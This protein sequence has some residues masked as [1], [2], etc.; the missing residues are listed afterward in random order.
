MHWGESRQDDDNGTTPS[1]P[2]KYNEGITHRSKVRPAGG[3]K[4]KRGNS[5][6]SPKKNN[7]CSL[8]ARLDLAKFV[9]DDDALMADVEGAQGCM[10]RSKRWE[11]VAGRLGEIG[12]SRTAEDCR[13]LKKWVELV[14]K[15][16]EIRD[17]CEGLRK[18]AYWDTTTKQ[19]RKLGKSVTCDDTLAS[20][21]LRGGGSPSGG[22]AGSEG[23]G[24]DAADT[25]TKTRHTSSGKARGGDSPASMYM[26]SVME[27]STRALCEVLDKAVGTLARASTDGSRMVATE[28]RAVVGAMRQGNA[29]LETLVGVMAARGAGSG[30]GAD[31]SRDTDP[32]TTSGS[33][34]A[35]AASNSDPPAKVG[36]FIPDD[37][38]MLTIDI[39]GDIVLKLVENLA[40][41]HERRLDMVTW[42]AAVVNVSEV[43]MVWLIGLRL[44]RRPPIVKLVCLATWCT[45]LLA[46]VVNVGEV[47][48]V[49][50][51]GLRIF[52]RPV[53][54]RVFVSPRGTQRI[55]PVW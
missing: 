47:A 35:S 2:A 4:R 6:R 16:R 45:G 11:W 46:G 37:W 18:Q 40:D 7:P 39:V 27:E 14:K 34:L 19:R 52:R 17:A 29:I 8:E 20:E 51:T 36:S 1:T 31:D 43:A 15:V 32:S 49:R 9:G 28:I 41:E 42:M 33:T 48:M 22:E 50:L 23:V 44:R 38:A 53:S 10:T 13:N 54:V 30:Q 25:A 24:T 12:Y 55:W 26:P 3:Q 21:D 5:P